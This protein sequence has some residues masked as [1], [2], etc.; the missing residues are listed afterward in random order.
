VPTATATLVWTDEPLPGSPGHLLQQSQF[1]TDV[2]LGTVVDP[3]GAGTSK[4]FAVPA[5]AQAIVVIPDGSGPP[6]EINVTGHTT[7]GQYLF[8]GTPLLANVY[9]APAWPGEDPQIDVFCQGRGSGAQT[10]YVGYSLAAKAIAVVAPKGEELAVSLN[11]V[12]GN[13]IVLGQDAT[14]PNGAKSIPVVPAK[15]YTPALWQAPTNFVGND[16]AAPANGTVVLAAVAGQ[17]YY[18]FGWEIVLDPTAAGNTQFFALANGAA[19]TNRFAASPNQAASSPSIVASGNLGG[20]PMGVNT[21]IQLH[22]AAGGAG[23]TVRY[24]LSY[25][26]G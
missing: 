11:D 18:V 25:S 15:N 13:P 23:T 19:A 9:S 10:F 1:A 3:A 14:L 21:G 5:G 4:T 24:K 2:A 8:V 6:Q 7:G 26:L 22:A 12:G 16:V 20:C 17:Q